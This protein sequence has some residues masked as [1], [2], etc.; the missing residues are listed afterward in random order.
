MSGLHN[1]NRDLLLL[2][3]TGEL[4]PEELEYTAAQLHKILFP[5]ESHL[6]FCSV[7]EV[8]DV[9]RF[10]VITKPHKVQQVIADRGRNPFVFICCR[11]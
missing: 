9:N 7:H 11:N 1:N 4:S 6:H 2:S 8:I 10:K 3:R 5:I